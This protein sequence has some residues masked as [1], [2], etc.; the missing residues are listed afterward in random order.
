AWPL[1]AVGKIDKRQL[2]A[3]AQ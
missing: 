3:L 2:A 1:T